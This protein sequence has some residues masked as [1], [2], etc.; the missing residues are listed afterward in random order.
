MNWPAAFTV[1]GI[2]GCVCGLMGW[3]A[4]VVTRYGNASEGDEE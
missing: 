4:Y 3:I 2:M 1:V